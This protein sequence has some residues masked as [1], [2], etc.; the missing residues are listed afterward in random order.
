MHR[1]GS[2]RTQRG[3]AAIEM[4]IA[5]PVLL[6]LLVA[7]AELGRAFYQYNTLAKSVRNA[8]RYLSVEAYEG[9]LKIIDLTDA[10]LAAT[11][12]LVVYSNTSGGGEPIIAGLDPAA[13]I[14]TEVDSAHVEV[15]ASFAYQPMFLSIPT[16]GY[17]GSAIDTGF[18]LSA[19]ATMRAL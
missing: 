3:V 10:K 15:A 8:A 2:K 16:F 14:V 4:A 11:K 18:T 1:I 9:T 7:T 6:L 13:V 19:S 12:N 5:L 17:T